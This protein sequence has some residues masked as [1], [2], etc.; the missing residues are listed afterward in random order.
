MLSD[1]QLFYGGGISNQEE[2]EEM[3][4]IADTIIVGD[5]VY[6]DIQNALKTVKI[7]ESHK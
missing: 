3:A 1:T 2:A 4:S 6:K 5:I 7:K